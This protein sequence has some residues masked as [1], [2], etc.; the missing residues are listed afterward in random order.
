MDENEAGRPLRGMATVLFGCSYGGV[1]PRTI[2]IEADTD[3]ITDESM[4]AVLSAGLVQ[5]AVGL[6]WSASVLGWR[7]PEHGPWVG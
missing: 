5:A 3:G 6:G 4:F 7:C 2:Q 1:C